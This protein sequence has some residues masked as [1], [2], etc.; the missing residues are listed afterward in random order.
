MMISLFESVNRILTFK[1][2]IQITT[3]IGLLLFFGVTWPTIYRDYPY[4]TGS[5]DEIATYNTSRV[6]FHKNSTRF[7]QYGSLDTGQQLIANWWYDNFDIVG[8]AHPVKHFSNSVKQSFFDDQLAKKP[9][10]WEHPY[11]RHFRGLS[12]RYQIFISRHIHFVVLSLLILGLIVLLN[13]EFGTAGAVAAL[14]FLQFL[15]L[16]EFSFSAIIFSYKQ[17]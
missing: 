1:S 6:V 15:F 14:V 2:I 16:K 13:V 12:D 10:I 7:Y 3:I 5:W 8:K 17:K 11:F 4:E 9:K